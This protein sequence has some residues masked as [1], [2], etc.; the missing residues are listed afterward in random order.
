MVKI[1]IKYTL[2]NRIASFDFAPTKSPTEFLQRGSVRD[3]IHGG[4]V[5]F[6][7]NGPGTRCNPAEFIFKK[8]FVFRRTTT[9]KPRRG[10]RGSSME[11]MEYRSACRLDRRG[12]VFGREQY[13]LKEVPQRVNDIRNHGTD[14]CN[15]RTRKNG[16]G[17]F[18]RCGFR[19]H[20]PDEP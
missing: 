13:R 9:K 20:D 5:S 6:R 19:E 18:S 11:I 8:Y 14:N 17:Q 3:S 4:V 15:D 7:R 1:C 12:Y 16:G 10:G 2:C